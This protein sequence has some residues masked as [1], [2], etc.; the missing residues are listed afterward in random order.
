MFDDDFAQKCVALFRA[1]TVEAGRFA[2]VVHSLVQGCH[3]SRHKRAGYVAD[4][5]A[6]NALFGVCF[7]EGGDLAGYFRKKIVA[8]QLEKIAI[9]GSHLWPL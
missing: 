9:Y 8:L 1:V 4:T 7:L 5:Q 3:N 2:H 6:D